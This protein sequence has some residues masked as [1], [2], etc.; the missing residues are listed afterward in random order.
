MR[1][2]PA[3][4]RTSVWNAGHVF[5]SI[6]KMIAR[7]ARTEP[8]AAFRQGVH[9][10]LRHSYILSKFYEWIDLAIRTGDGEELLARDHDGSRRGGQCTDI[11]S[12]IRRDDYN[13]RR[14]WRVREV[15]TCWAARLVQDYTPRG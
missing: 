9:H 2:T 15:A 4:I 10:K 12:V 8:V 5:C 7:D 6:L 13:S 14:K 1:R 3:A 11:A